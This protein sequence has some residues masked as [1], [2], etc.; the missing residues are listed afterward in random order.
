MPAFFSS[1]LS[2]HT[3]FLIALLLFLFVYLLSGI[4]LGLLIQRLRDQSLIRREREDAVK[5]SRAVLAGLSGE[6]LAPL[7]PGFPCDA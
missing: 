7:L 2:E 5:R 4:L 3:L 6:Q 1:V